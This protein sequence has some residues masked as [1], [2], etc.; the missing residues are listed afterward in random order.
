MPTQEELEI[1]IKAKDLATK[2]LDQIQRDLKGIGTQTKKTNTLMTSF[3]GSINKL[4]SSVFS[5]RGLFATLGIGMLA[6]SF[7]GAASAAEQYRTRLRVLMGDVNEANLLFKD[8]SEFA[9]GVSFE[10][11]QIMGS[12]TAL[13]GVMKGGREEIAQ[14]MPMIADLAATAGMGIEETTSQIIRMYSAGAASADM[15]RERGILAMLGFQAGVSITAEKTRKQLISAW[16][17]PASKFRGASVL[18]SHTWDGMLSMMSDAWFQFRNLVMEGGVYDYIKASLDML[19][20]KIKTLKEEGKLDVWAASMASKVLKALKGIIVAA[21]VVGDAFKGWKLILLGLKLLG[22]TL[23][24]TYKR[25]MLVINELGIKVETF[26]DDMFYGAKVLWVK[27]KNLFKRESKKL[28]LPL[29][30][31]S[32]EVARLKE[33]GKS[34]E[35]DANKYRKAGM[36]LSKTIQDLSSSSGLEKAKGVLKELDAAAEKFGETF[37]EASNRMKTPIKTKGPSPLETLVSDLNKIKELGKTYLVEIN[38]ALD[39]GTM[40]IEKYY[41]ERER[42]VTEQYEKEVELLKK[43]LELEEK[44]DKK[45]ALRDKLFTAEEAHQRALLQLQIER[46]KRE[47]EYNEKRLEAEQIIA[48]I[49]DRVLDQRAGTLSESFA[50]ELRELDNRQQEELKNLRE[51][52]KAIQDESKKRKLIKDAE[53]AHMQEKNQLLLDQERR[54]HEFRLEIARDTAGGLA[55]VFSDLY[56]TTGRKTKEFFYL[57]KAAAIA[58]AIINNSLAITKAMAQGGWWGIGQAALIAAKGALEISKISAQSLGEGGFVMGKSPTA[59]A[60]DKL[61]RA[62]SGEFMQPIDAVRYY[63]GRIMNGIKNKIFP[64]EMFSNFSIP[65]ARGPSS[66]ALAGGGSVPSNGVQMAGQG[67]RDIMIANYYDIN[68]FFNALATAKGRGA[69]VNVIGQEKNTIKRILR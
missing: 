45:Q 18:L 46:D 67:E 7:I 42:L 64:K 37:K 59:T 30:I 58:E 25:S 68:E 40:S 62:T 50:S 23:A 6:R 9:A 48:N 29:K 4:K 54:L 16:E 34:L 5:L 43:K 53:T 8:M 10:Y 51:M 65:S 66:Y 14:W 35:E 26:F 52:T 21:Y 36:E 3:R 47:E 63:G 39:Q 61:I 28:Q 22:V 15:F 17:D 13:A 24:E 38:H 27:F 2:A 44:D 19:L 57:S 69:I 11:E 31:E 33:V 41:S 60:D 56:E 1:I 55:D 49:Q 20:G 32:A 12:A